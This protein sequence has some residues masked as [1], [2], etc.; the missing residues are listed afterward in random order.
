METLW[1]ADPANRTEVGV[2][3]AAA[4][5]FLVQFHAENPQA[6]PAGP[7]ITAVR[8]YIELTGTYWHTREE[9][10]FGARVAW[11]NN[12]RCI[13]R[14]YWRSLQVRDLRTVTDATGIAGHC[15]QH[16]RQ[17]HNGG[18]I[19]PV[20]TVFAPEAP[21]RPAPRI[22][23]EQLIRYAGYD[24]PDGSVLGDPRN[25]ELT[26]EAIDRGWRPP[27]PRGAFD[28]LPL[29]V[30]TAE[31]GTRM[32]LLPDD[33]VHEVA[34]EHPDLAWFAELGLRWHAV[35][36]ISN[37]RLDI[38]GISYPAAPFNGWYMGTE[39]GARNL[40]DID[41]YDLV[42]TVAERMG[43]DTSDEAT[44]W[45]DRA[46]VELNRAVLH[47]FRR[48]NTTITDHHTESRRFLTHLEREEQAG[49]RCPADW[50]WIVPPMSGSQTPVFH[51]YYDGDDLLPNFFAGSSGSDGLIPRPEAAAATGPPG[52]PPAPR[53]GCRRGP[54]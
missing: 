7:R 35:P 25:R 51:R 45:R 21:S 16:L 36:V 41:R 31:E 22:R 19:R 40:A 26:L 47:S 2:D 10:A 30:E 13:G 5:E 24:L 8:R 34:L 15:A 37:N 32:F 28:V 53:S 42:P 18:K 9:L 17:A 14:L 49:R 54:H 23:N 1:R 27:A 29:V 20:I 46:L 43:L 39:I 44:L 38:G 33:A 3:P 6:G 52:L 48:D 50:S 11:R 12:A 4:E